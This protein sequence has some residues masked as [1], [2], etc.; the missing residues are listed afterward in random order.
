[1]KA[2]RPIN[3][4]VELWQVIEKLAKEKNTSMARIIEEKL[5]KDEEIRKIMNEQQRKR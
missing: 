3:M 2:P 1:M 4:D 5:K